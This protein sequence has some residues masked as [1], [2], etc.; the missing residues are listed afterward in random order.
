[1]G[2]YAGDGLDQ[3][4]FP[5]LSPL[6]FILP[7]DGAKDDFEERDL[8]FQRIS[9]LITVRSDVFT[10]Y[11]LVR[12]GADGPQRRMIAILDRSG[13]FPRSTA[14]YTSGKVKVRAL[15]QVPDPW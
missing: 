7:L 13:V 11:I 5:D 10:A 1:M 14:P 3:R 2:Y 12:I 4:G 6:K 15:H 9:N 8:I